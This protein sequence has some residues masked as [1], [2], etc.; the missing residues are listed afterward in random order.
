MAGGREGLNSC[1][2]PS[3]GG[4]LARWSW[5]T[6]SKYWRQ[7]N[8]RPVQYHGMHEAKPSNTFGSPSY[9]TGQAELHHW[10]SFD[11]VDAAGREWPFAVQWPADEPDAPD[12]C[13]GA[14]WMRDT[15]QYLAQIVPG[16]VEREE[17]TVG[18]L[19]YE[20]RL[21]SYKR[22][23]DLRT[24]EDTWQTFRDDIAGLGIE[25][26]RHGHPTTS[27]MLTA[28]QVELLISVALRL[29]R[30]GHPPVRSQPAAGSSTSDGQ[31]GHAAE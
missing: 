24:Y 2:A 5:A 19:D 30:E 21:D 14:V 13:W 27:R 11:I 23:P 15:Q 12:G 20:Q 8:I 1:R 28:L 3:S 22:H 26:W 18:V 9:A 31:S 16:E 29:F 6:P 10:L 25:V 4:R 7:Y 17:S